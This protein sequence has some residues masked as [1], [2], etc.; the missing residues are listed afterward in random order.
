[1]KVEQGDIVDVNFPMPEGG[2]KAHPAIVISN[3]DLQIDE[4]FFYCVL[5]ST[6]DYNSKYYIEL[7]DNMVSKPMKQKSFVKCQIIGGLTEFDVIKKQGRVKSETVEIIIEKII[8][9]IF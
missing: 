6:K 8:Q 5:I 9:S 3:N 7:K 4:E 1:M 2:F